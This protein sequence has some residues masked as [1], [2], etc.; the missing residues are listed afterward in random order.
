[1]SFHT[2]PHPL[3]PS[4]FSFCHLFFSL[5][6]PLFYPPLYCPPTQGL[7]G[8]AA[9]GVSTLFRYGSGA[10]R[11]A[12]P[13]LS[14][15]SDY[16]WFAASAALFLTLPMVVE[17][18]RETTVLVMQRQREAELAHAQEMGKQQNASVID[19]VKQ[20]GGALMASSGGAQ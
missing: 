13:V 1:M 16:A 17:I 11:T 18:Q 15:V 2:S 20:I 10:Y 8:R 6:L 4:F 5:C 3:P 19:N 14:F 7:F 9:A 12:L